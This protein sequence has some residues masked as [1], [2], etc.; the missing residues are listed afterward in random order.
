[1]TWCI[2]RDLYRYWMDL[3]CYR[4]ICFF[5]YGIYCMYCISWYAVLFL[6]YSFWLVCSRHEELLSALNW[7]RQFAIPTCWSQRV[8]K[9]AIWHLKTFARSF[10]LGLSKG[11]HLVHWRPRTWLSQSEKE[12]LEGIMKQWWAFTS[13]VWSFLVEL[14]HVSQWLCLANLCSYYFLLLA[15]LVSSRSEKVHFA[16]PGNEEKNTNKLFC[17][18]CLLQILFFKGKNIFVHLGV[19][20]KSFHVRRLQVESIGR[21]VWA[22][23]PAQGTES[24]SLAIQK[25]QCWYFLLGDTGK[26]YN[27]I[28]T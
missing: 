18:N 9:S 26:W 10:Q 1:M 2:L 19:L 15:L 16:W 6:F 5:I 28:I 14:S 20:R 27:Q 3:C 13:S 8:F 25:T 4:R 23:A 11:E 22:V 24:S 21:V 17:K 7:H 12:K